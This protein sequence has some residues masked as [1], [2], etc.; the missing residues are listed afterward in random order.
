MKT[1]RSLFVMSALTAG[2]LSAHPAAAQD[3]DLEF[4]HAMQDQGYGDVAVD[5]LKMVQKRKDL[6]DAIREVWNFEM[7]RSLKAAAKV[8]YTPEEAEKLTNEAQDYL[9][10]FLKENPNHPEAM[11]AL[12]TWGSFP[13]DNALKDIR[14]AEK[15]KDAAERA[16]LLKGAR[17]GLE[18]ARGRFRDAATKLQARLNALPPLPKGAKGKVISKQVQRQIA[19]REDL[20][21]NIQSCRFQD[22]LIDYYLAQTYTDPKD[23]ARAAALKKASKGFDAIWQGN[24]SNI[25]VL[26][27]F[28][29]GL[30]AHMW[31]G[32][33]HEKWGNL[34]TALDIYDEVL[35]NDSDPGTRGPSDPEMDALFAQV[36]LF[37]LQIVKTKSLNDFYDEA[38]GWLDAYG[39]SRLNLD[40][41]QAIALELVKTQLEQAEKAKDAKEKARL[42]GEAMA[43][44]AEMAKIRSAY[45]KE[46]ILLRRGVAKTKTGGGAE[47]GTFEEAVA[48]GDSAAAIGQWHEAVASYQRAVD[49]SGKFTGKVKPVDREK[50]VKSLHEDLANA[51]VRQAGDLAKKNNLEECLAAAEK[52]T[53][54]YKDTA[55]APQAAA[56]RVAA[57]LD[58]YKAVPADKKDQ[59]GKALER[60]EELAKFTIDNWPGKR[61]ADDARMALGQA[62]LVQGKSDEALKV[63]EAV[64]PKSERYP[65]A[66]LMAAKVYWYRYLT[67]RN[68]AKKD[69]L[70]AYRQK[71]VAQLRESL[72]V[73]QEKAKT[74]K[75]LSPTLIETQL[76]LAETELEANNAKEAAALLQPLYDAL[77]ET[78]P[79]DNITIRVFVGIIKAH[80]ALNELEK[81]TGVGVALAESGP[82]IPVVNGELIKFVSELESQRAA[83]EKEIREPK[84]PQQAEAAKQKLESARQVL[85]KVVPKLVGRQQ[86]SGSALVYVGDMC[87]AVG[88]TEAARDQYARVVKYAEENPA[89]A[90]A[91]DRA[92]TRARSQLIDLLLDE[93]KYEE[94]IKHAEELVKQYPR[95][96]GPKMKLGRALD[97]RAA[98]EPATYKE[99]L[100][101]WIKLRSAIEEGL[102]QLI[103][104]RAKP[105]V[106]AKMRR[107]YYDVTCCLAECYL[108]QATKTSDKTA[109]H[110]TALDG[111]RV[112]ESDLA[113]N[114]KLD[115][116]DS[117]DKYN[118]VKQKISDFLKA[119]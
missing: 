16:K 78:K 113:L 58:L 91:A 104:K 14:A 95:A 36:E 109:A 17:A 38:K 80:L 73:Q 12:A 92:V 49:L 6:P 46:F 40:G 56:L 103:S 65:V 118:K 110:K 39:K 81:A 101:H 50:A 68:T 28:R 97:A 67:E 114:P 57:A 44:A 5:Y 105:E 32:K 20:E 106:I 2:C 48:L 23:P 79:E 69:L 33:C 63:F 3:A 116:P 119:K 117:V 76:V 35:G 90:K 62:S 25:G 52:V 18:E 89:Y 13:M 51:M 115:G 1:L 26:G 9:N 88:Q 53:K 86:M 96:L 71:A 47:A 7:S 70:A 29:I 10:K 107:E 77:K 111:A 41:Y 31:D 94:A 75:T 83:A 55:A 45:Q 60:L 102:S 54:D 85:A 61:E 93:G 99:T 42:I 112:L 64:N 22:A 66:L 43:R 27:L 87:A 11:A 8:A 108:A 98:K 72:K 4:I 74:E 19:Q 34:V 100:T 84:S 82:D 37:R 24:R 59:K 15:T 30:Y 21:T